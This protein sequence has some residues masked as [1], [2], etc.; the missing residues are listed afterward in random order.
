MVFYI[1]VYSEPCVVGE[2]DQLYV[3]SNSDMLWFAFAGLF[4]RVLST[5]WPQT[6][7]TPP[8]VSLFCSPDPPLAAI[9]CI[10]WSATS[11][12]NTGARLKHMEP[13]VR[14]LHRARRLQQ[15]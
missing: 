13:S 4:H 1:V 7:L 12:G 2:P 6:A 14:P 15:T 3:R 5:L 8:D 10:S 9:V 11:C